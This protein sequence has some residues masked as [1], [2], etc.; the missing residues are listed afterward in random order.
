MVETPLIELLARNGIRPDR[1]T[2]DR[3]MRLVCPQCGGGR[4]KEKSLALRI[5]SDGAGAAWTCHRGTCGWSGGVHEREAPQPQKRAPAKPRRPQPP[6]NPTRPDGLY[7]WFAKRGISRETVD[8]FG[9]YVAKQFFPQTEREEWAFAFPYR[10]AGELINVKYRKSDE[11]LHCQERGAER[12]LFNFD[13]LSDNDVAIIVEGE[14]DVM[15]LF[16]AGFPNAVTLPDGSPAKLPEK[17]NPDDKRYQALADLE[18]MPQVTTFILAG[19][20]D[21]PGLNHREE[22]ARRLGKDRCLI[23]TWPDGCKDANDTLLRHGPDMVRASME[24]ARPHPI[25]SLF[26]ARD[27]EADVLRIYRE[28]RAR[29]AS[30]GWRSLD[31]YLSIVPGWISVVTGVPSSGKSEFVDALAVNLAISLDWRFVVCSF[32]NPPEEHIAK[33]AEKYLGMPFWDGR[34]ARMGEGD[35]L[36]AIAWINDHFVFIRSDDEIPTFDW[37]LEKATAAVR[38][39][40]CRGLIIDPYNEIEHQRPAHQTETDYISQMLARLRRFCVSHAVHAWFVAHPTKPQRQ[41]DGSVPVPTMYD[42]AGS[43][44]WVNKMDVGISVER[45]KVEGAPEV[46]IHVKK[47][48]FKWAGR[49][50]TAV[51]HY[52]VATGQYR[53]QQNIYILGGEE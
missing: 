39:Y 14:L 26:E 22:I 33:L 41:S 23:V 27:F 30:T 29:G 31:E 32:E 50:G 45:S 49:R 11:K 1:I 24:R 12:S 28:G 36:R 5:D 7:E 20:D 44:N 47:V 35:L 40:G 9:I 19:D 10:R 53:D 48:R 3:E 8:A 38:R 6:A 34:R 46:M 13:A 2:A 25:R 16:E 37:I 18:Q 21:A 52:D 51:L 15:A 42:I 43:A 17:P 4:S